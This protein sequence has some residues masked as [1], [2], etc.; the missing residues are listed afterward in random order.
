M[1]LVRY[2]YEGR[3]APE[4]L[5]SGEHL[6]AF[7][8]R[9]IVVLVSVKEEERSVDLV[10][11]VEWTLFHIEVG[12][13]PRIGFRH[14]YF[15]VGV[16]PVAFS[17]IACVVTDT[18]V[19]DCRSEDV[20]DCLQILGHEAAVGCADTSDFLLVDIW[21]LGAKLLVPSMMS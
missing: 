12:I 4:K 6:Y 7:P 11:V 8:Y 3:G 15:A 16:A 17:P 10:C 20:G 5:E 1:V 21:M 13:A 19:G 14:R 9:Y 2:S 18:G